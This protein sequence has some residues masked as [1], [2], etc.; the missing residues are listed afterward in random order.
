MK[1][2]RYIILTTLLSIVCVINS[3]AE[4]TYDKIQL[5]IENDKHKEALNLT[6]DYL[7]RNKSDIKFQ[8]LKGLILAR[9]NRYNDAEKI[10]YKMA[11]E[12]PNL[13]EPLNN[14]AVIYSIQGEYSKAQEILKKAL[15]SN[16]NYETVYHNLSDLYAKVAS[17][18]YNQ[19][20][21]ISQTER[22]P[23]EKL[24]FLRELNLPQ[25]MLIESLNRENKELKSV[26]KDTEKV[27]EEN[28]LA[29]KIK[30]QELSKLGEAQ[31]SIQKLM[32]E[33]L[34]LNIE[35]KELKGSLDEVMYSL[36]LK[37]EQLAK[38][39]ETEKALAGLTN[40][41]KGLKDRLV[42]AEASLGQLSSSLILKDEQLA[43]LDENLNNINAADL[44]KENS[45]LKS[46]VNET[47]LLLEELK[48]SVADGAEDSSPDI[49]QK[50]NKLSEQ[51]KAI[52]IA[53]NNW[54]NA[55]ASKNID[56][57]ISSYAM[58]FKPSR[59]LSRAKWELQRRERL[60]N[61]SFIKIKLT[62][63][64]IEIRD[65][66]L[67]NVRFTQQYQSDSYKDEVKKIVTVKMINN[68]WLIMRER[69]L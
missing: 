50:T 18:A 2:V 6:E 56:N 29:I 30:N 53:I 7:S 44:K 26:M 42:K 22:G 9:L 10:F 15:E 48:K 58:E 23:I 13:P 16:R 64:K 65:D 20:L 4:I 60:A 32:Q 36:S 49:G 45:N 57:Y 66:G 35:I 8:F 39:D 51:K 3:S 55:W 37:D 61:P 25:T 38:L 34:E 62:N 43:K 11:E 47:E 27:L 19:A 41:N 24:L 40:E 14:L 21:G 12:N 69:V 5:L 63:I 28:K 59:G 67:A 46:K 1:I 54:V 33:K 52:E 17:R 68:K 31:R